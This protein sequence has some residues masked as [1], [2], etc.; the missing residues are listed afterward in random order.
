MWQPLYLLSHLLSSETE[1]HV[2]Q[3]VPDSLCRSGWPWTSGSLASTLQMLWVHVFAAVPHSWLNP[4]VLCM[5]SKYSLNQAMC[6]SQA[7]MVWIWMEVRGQLFKSCFSPSI[8]CLRPCLE[9]LTGCPISYFHL[10]LE[11]WDCRHESLLVPNM[12]SRDCTQALEHSEPSYQQ[13]QSLLKPSNYPNKSLALKKLRHWY[14]TLSW[15]WRLRVKMFS[16]FK[17]II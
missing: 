14:F 2:F 17:K 5:L 11:C 4:K 7:W 13:P 15:Y 10:L 3:L 12:G 1:S 9:L 8:L 16:S 6:T